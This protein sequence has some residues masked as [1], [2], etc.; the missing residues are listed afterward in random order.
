MDT[1][2]TAATPP[3]P[4]K[5]R[6]PSYPAFDLETTLTRAQQLYDIAGSHGVPVPAALEAWGFTEKSSNGSLT[7][8]ALKRF[9]LAN[10][11]GKRGARSVV[12]TR[13]GQE[14]VVYSSQR[15]AQEW[16]DGVKRAA[17]SPAIHADLWAKY[18]GDL[19]ADAVIRPHLVID[20]GF[21]D[22]AA[23]ELLREFRST[24]EFANLTSADGAA[25]LPKT[26]DENG[27]TAA[28]DSSEPLMPVP[29][30]AVPEPQVTPSA[31]AGNSQFLS[32]SERTIQV[33]YSPKG[34]A[35]LK[36]EFPMS[37]TEWTQMLAVLAAMK[38][39]LVVDDD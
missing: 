7:I 8:A 29:T 20:L 5:H 37:E 9:S 38:P 34:W 24:I 32:T 12:L 30:I 16:K 15:D 25:T 14:L 2:P 39:S 10:D 19:P 23:R 17:L 28:D 33:P 22:S 6:S 18:G 3:K 13:L 4:P 31:T 26:G 36:A 11:E 21:S 35:L 27:P 1:E